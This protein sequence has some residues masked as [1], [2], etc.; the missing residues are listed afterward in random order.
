M[1]TTEINDELASEPPSIELRQA[2]RYITAIGPQTVVGTAVERWGKYMLARFVV[3]AFVL[4][5]L[6]PDASSQLESITVDKPSEF[7]SLKMDK[8]AIPASARG[9]AGST[10]YVIDT[11]VVRLLT[12]WDTMDYHIGDTTRHLYA[13]TPTGKWTMDLKQKLVGENWENQLRDMYAYDEDDNQIIESHEVWQN[14]QWVGWYRYTRTFDDAH[15]MLS[16]VVD[17]WWD[18]RWQ[19]QARRLYTYDSYRHKLTELIQDYSLD[20]VNADL[21][22]ATYDAAG[23]RTSELT[24]TWSENHWVSNSLHTYSYDAHGN[25]LTSEYDI[26]QGGALVKSLRM[27]YAYDT[28]DNRLSELWER[29][30]FGQWTPTWR[31]TYTYDLNKN[32]LDTLLETYSNDQLTPEWRRTYTYDSNGNRVIFVSQTYSDSQWSNTTRYVSAYDAT[33]RLI[34]ITKEDWKDSAQTIPIRSTRR[35]WSIVSCRWSAM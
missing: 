3:L 21:Y 27:T 8:P 31:F 17:T 26:A 24:Q 2:S 1:S 32:Q 6:C 19:H 20:W 7:P 29:P 16:Y 13:F 25:M 5:Q 35:Q 18:D 23:N 10:F 11:A 9:N 12:W 28:D 33:N 14:G 34:S 15:C 4:S 30:K 22:S